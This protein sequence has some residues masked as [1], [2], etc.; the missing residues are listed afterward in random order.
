[1]NYQLQIFNTYGVVVSIPSGFNICSKSKD[2]RGI[3]S[4]FNIFYYYIES[5]TEKKVV[6][7]VVKINHK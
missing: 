7:V 3:P 6:P 1:M 2:K 4:G 5:I